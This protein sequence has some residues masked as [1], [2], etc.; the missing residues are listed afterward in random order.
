M[1]MALETLSVFQ[2][3]SAK[4]SLS[5]SM[6]WDKDPVNGSHDASNIGPNTTQATNGTHTMDDTGLTNTPDAADSAEHA[7]TINATD[8]TDTGL[9]T[10]YGSITSNT[11]QDH[12]DEAPLATQPVVPPIEVQME[13][14]PMSLPIEL[15][16]PLHSPQH[17]ANQSEPLTPL[18]IDWFLHSEPG[19]PVHGGHLGSSCYQ[20]S[21]EVFGDSIWAPFSSQCEWEIAHWAKMRGLMS[22]AMEELLAIPELIKE[23]ND[24]INALPGRPSF[25][26]Y[27]DPAFSQD[28]V[29]APERHYADQEWMEHVYSKMHMGD[30]WWAVQTSLES[31]QPGVTVVPLIISSDKMQLTLF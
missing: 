14:P 16:L 30:W 25:S 4:G 20:Q 15:L 31:V 17:D 6:S 10:K 22:S 24:I 2:S 19:A 13:D 27:D 9:L 11:N 28:L 8:S 18:V 7:D 1:Q 3:M 29:V 23:L 26:I 12:P 5:N 21:Q